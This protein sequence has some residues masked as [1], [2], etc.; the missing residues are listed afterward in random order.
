[1]NNNLSLE[2]IYH[3]AERVQEV[4]RTTGM[5][6]AFNV[7][8]N[9]A[10]L[11]LKA[12]NLQVTG[13][14][15]VRGAYCKLLTLTEE[16]K[17]RGVVACSAGNHAQGVALAAK[18][19]GIDATIFIPSSAPLSK[20][21][22]TESYGAKV[23]LVDGVYDDAYE[24]SLKHAKKSGA[25]FVH[26]FDDY[27]VI[28]GQ[29]T[30]GVEILQQL[31]DVECIVA[32]IGG[33]GL[34]AGIAYYVKQINPNIKVYG[35]QVE[36]AASM[37]KSFK[38][39]KI[40]TLS[41]VSTFADGIAVKCPGEFTF[42]MCQKYV[43]DVVTVSDDEIASAVLALMEGQKIVAEGAGAACVAALMHGKLPVEGKKCVAVVSG[44]NIDVNILSRVINRGLTNAGRVTELTI[45][46][47]DKPGQLQA[48]SEIISKLG[49][50]VTKVRHDPLGEKSDI[51]GCFLHI[52]LETK[53]LAHLNEIEKAFQK[54]G[55]K[56]IPH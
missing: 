5:I 52:G 35:V 13:A 29:A 55:Y 28:A 45:E 32:S 4:A 37:H 15:K 24:E 3:A 43:D 9:A 51:K 56:I 8:T 41:N 34:V 10:E 50:N 49:A 27:D 53:N 17:S 54:E 40:C 30:I 2:K 47:I 22:A 16:E 25:V 18:K 21:E 39:D 38:S 11:Y 46:L 12:E 1:M 48:V 36:G 44:G 33:G 31:E 19:L 20:I 42:E 7:P 26:P 6:R 14:F 23:I